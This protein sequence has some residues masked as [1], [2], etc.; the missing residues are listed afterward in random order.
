MG[1]PCPVSL[2]AQATTQKTN[3]ENGHKSNGFPIFAHKCA[4]PTI[5]SLHETEGNVARVLGTALHPLSNR[6][7]GTG[8]R[9]RHDPA[10]GRRLRALCPLPGRSGTG[11]TLTDRPA[12]GTAKTT[13]TQTAQ[14]IVWPGGEVYQFRV[15]LCLT[16]EVLGKFHNAAG[17]L[18]KQLVHDWWDFEETITEN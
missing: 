8:V 13:A 17:V 14:S 9:L 15:A 7:G 10:H 6:R 4:F 18:D 16:P 3:R 2:S 12:Q 1:Q 5:T 11:T